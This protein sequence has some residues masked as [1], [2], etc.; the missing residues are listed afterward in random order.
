MYCRG[1]VGVAIVVSRGY[2]GDVVTFNTFVVGEGV[3]AVHQAKVV[4]DQ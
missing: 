3:T 4:L 2:N 1:F